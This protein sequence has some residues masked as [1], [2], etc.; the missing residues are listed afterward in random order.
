MLLCVGL[1]TN[2]SLK[3]GTKQGQ[4]TELDVSII[5]FQNEQQLSYLSFTFMELTYSFS[6]IHSNFLNMNLQIEH[7][8]FP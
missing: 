5:P 1:S 3:T 7:Y 4:F 8:S 2:G 6:P